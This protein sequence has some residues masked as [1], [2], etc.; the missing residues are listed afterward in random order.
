MEFERKLEAS[1]LPGDK[2]L[3]QFA[4]K[5]REHAIKSAE[6]VLIP[7]SR[8]NMPEIAIKCCSLPS[9]SRAKNIE[10]AVNLKLT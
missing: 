6:F 3:G 8:S 5:K 1:K 4:R 10:P 7:A 9:S 2:E